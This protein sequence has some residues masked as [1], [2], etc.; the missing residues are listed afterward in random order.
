MGTKPY[1]LSKPCLFKSIETRMPDYPRTRADVAAIRMDFLNRRPSNLEFLLE[2]RYSWINEFILPEETGIELGCG[3]GISQIFITSKNFKL[4]DIVE[5]PWVDMKIDALAMTLDDSSLDYIVAS[6]MIHHV[7]N[8]HLFI[9]EVSRVLKPRGRFIIQE[10]NCSFFMRLILRLMK[11]EGYS[12]DVD[13][14]DKSAICND[15][16]DPWSANCAISNMLFDVPE[17]F[18][19]R[20]PFKK[21]KIG[22][23]E[24]YARRILR[25]WPLYL[26]VL[27]L[28]TPVLNW[29]DPRQQMGAGYLL[30]FLFFS[31]NWVCAIQGY[32]Q[33]ALAPL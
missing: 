8:P 9:N 29:L 11:H 21:S 14:F 32:P 17:E 19:T 22:V 15:P 5:N 16:H 26:I 20:F 25:I 27:T 23:K 4:T 1:F 18:E 33:S 28:G 2:K 12:Y 30:A 31:G 7:A 13:V 24:F 10:I 6:N 3:S